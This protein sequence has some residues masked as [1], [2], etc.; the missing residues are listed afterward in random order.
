LEAVSTGIPLLVVCKV[1]KMVALLPVTITYE[2][3]RS[4]IIFFV[5]G[6]IVLSP[7]TRF[8]VV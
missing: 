4:M 1:A 3:S 8:G 2:L 6:A 5:P 7:L